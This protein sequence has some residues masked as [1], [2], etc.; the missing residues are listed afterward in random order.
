MITT[1][2]VLTMTACLLFIWS[3]STW[4]F[5][6]SNKELSKSAKVTLSEAVETAAEMAPGKAVEAQIGEEDDRV[7]YWIE[8]VDSKNATRTIYVD[9]ETGKVVNMEKD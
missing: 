9:A 2:R 1:S 3:G 5:F 4:A 7:V 8:V 6:E